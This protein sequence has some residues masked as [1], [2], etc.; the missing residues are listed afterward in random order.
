M[1]GYNTVELEQKI[2]QEIEDNPALE[3]GLERLESDNDDFN[4]FE[5][6]EFSDEDLIMGDYRSEDD[7]PDYKMKERQVLEDKVE[8]GSLLGDSESFIDGLIKQLHLREL[9]DL[10]MKIGE[11][12]I[13]NLDPDGYLRRDVNSISDDLLF[14]AGID[15]PT[16]KLKRLIAIIQDLDP[17]GL[18]AK[19]LREC[20]MIQLF[21]K[22]ESLAIT[23]AKRI[24]RHHFDA[25]SKK[26]FDRI[27]T[28]MRL[29]QQQLDEA[30]HEITILNP[31]PGYAINDESGVESQQ[32]IPDFF[33]ETI[34]NE[35]V[36]SLNDKNIPE[37]RLS[38]TYVNMLEDY[39][40]NKVNR[41][42]STRNAIQFTKQKLD[43]ARWFI[44]ALRERQRVLYATMKAIVDYQYDYFLSGDESDMRPMTQKDISEKLGLEIST[45]SRVVT[46]K[47]AQT[48]WGVFSLK[49][50][51]AD[52]MQT[53]SGEEVSTLEIKNYLTTI[54]E[55]EDKKKPYSDD[56]LCELLTEKGYIIA[57]RTVAKYREILGIP[58]AR[59]RK[60][61]KTD[62]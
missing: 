61:L 5:E 23:R 33:I 30:I 1:L 10:E 34:D 17:P 43:S 7:I 56:K 13:G 46:S 32:V 28:D 60:D 36:L 38:R 16:N 39:N 12:V 29:T 57:R 37:L 2:A 21:R 51:F 44:D 49:F 40:A 18:A 22:E 26:L 25:F 24:L 14:H 3:E 11:Y 58:V 6:D 52:G 42:K 47:Y 62:K 20:L 53:E 48:S 19:D 4:D 41:T 27:R 15:Y 55:N 45:I 8:Q 9:D 54:V 35:V 31:K 50:F 59:F